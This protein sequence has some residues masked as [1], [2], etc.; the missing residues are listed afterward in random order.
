MRGFSSFFLLVNGSM[1]EINFSTLK[2]KQ[3]NLLMDHFFLLDLR[4]PPMRVNGSYALHESLIKNMN[5]VYG[6]NYPY[7]PCVVFTDQKTL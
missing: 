1:F 3:V 7:I 5:F 2:K 4:V 6:L